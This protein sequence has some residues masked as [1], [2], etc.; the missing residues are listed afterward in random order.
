[1]STPEAEATAPLLELK[2]VSAYY[3]GLRAIRDVSL[4]VL[5]G[6][7]MCIVGANGAG[8]STLL[9]AITGLMTDDPNRD[10]QGE[11]HMNGTVTTRH[12]PHEIVELGVALVPEGRRLFSSM[13][14]EENLLAGA[15]LN[16]SRTDTQASL[17]EVYEL[18]PKLHDRRTQIVSKMSGGEQQMVS[19]G[20][21]LMSN[22]KLMLI[23]EMSLGLAPVV[24]ADIA[25]QIRK[26]HDRGTT[27]VL[28]EQEI[29][30]AFDLA[31]HMSVML[32]GHLVL[33]GTPE[34][35]ERQQVIDAYFGVDHARC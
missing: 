35:L 17:E 27:F 28:V 11:I 4:T 14:V 7:I 3:G 18:F 19:I 25:N 1:M 8:K 9:A 6:E 29:G 23:D 21:A 32:E 31:T 12:A 13:S 30:R 33:E 2:S 34:E 24:V 5:A 22:P 26:I 15:Y 10:L 16:T 20:R